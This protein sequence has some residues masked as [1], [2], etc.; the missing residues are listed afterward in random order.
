M[1]LG[2]ADFD[3]RWLALLGKIGVEESTSD[4]GYCVGPPSILYVFQLIILSFFFSST[5]SQS[6]SIIGAGGSG[7]FAKAVVGGE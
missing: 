1:G 7:L 4:G 2:D 6:S 5:H 3:M